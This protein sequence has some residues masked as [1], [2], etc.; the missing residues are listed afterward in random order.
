MNYVMLAMIVA[1]GG[2]WYYNDVILAEKRNADPVYQAE[3]QAERAESF[4]ERTEYIKD[5]STGICFALMRGVTH[6]LGLATVDCE[7]LNSARV[8]EFQSH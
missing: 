1:F 2:F 4:G 7:L 6:G 3:R 8:I 5:T